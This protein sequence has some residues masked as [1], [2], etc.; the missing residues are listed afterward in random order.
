M[1]H[2]SGPGCFRSTPTEASNLHRIGGWSKESREREGPPARVVEFRSGTRRNRTAPDA[3]SESAGFAKQRADHTQVRDDGQPSPRVRA[4][5][6]TYDGKRALLDLSQILATS[7]SHFGIPSVE[8]PQCIAGRALDLG[9]RQALPVAEVEFAQPRVQLSAKAPGF[10]ENRRGL[11][12]AEKIAGNKY[13]DGFAGEFSSEHVRLLSSA[14]RERWVSV[15]LPATR[16]VPARFGV[17]DQ[18]QRRLA[19]DSKAVGVQR[20]ASP[21]SG[22]ANASPARVGVKQ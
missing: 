21:A 22:S 12:C 18:Q 7:G 14:I 8:A 20:R 5:E 19:H 17:P 2:P 15:P 9:A 4:D 16:R 11:H 1:A 3:G 13:V 10:S 6:F